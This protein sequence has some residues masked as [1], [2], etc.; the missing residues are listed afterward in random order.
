MLSQDNASRNGFAY[1][2]VVD[3][4]YAMMPDD[5]A[6]DEAPPVYPPCPSDY[7]EAPDAWMRLREKNGSSWYSHK[8][9][10]GWCRRAA[11]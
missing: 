7:P 11:K 10:E 3:A 1:S 5:G 2:P 4:P 9:A 8:T 6:F